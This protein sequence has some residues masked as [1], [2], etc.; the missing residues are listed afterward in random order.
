VKYAI[1][2][3][4]VFCAVSSA[5]AVWLGGDLTF[6]SKYIWRGAVFN[7]KPVLQ[8]WVASGIGGASVTVWGN[9]DLTDQNSY[10]EDG[11]QQDPT[12]KFTEI[13]L[14]LNYSE[15]IGPVSLTAGYNKYWYP[16]TSYS[17]TAASELTLSA[18]L[19]AFL[20]PTLTSA[21]SMEDAEGI[22]TALTVS[23][24]KTLSDI[25]SAGLSLNL[26]YGNEKH[27]GYY[28][29]VPEGGLADLTVNLSVPFA[30]PCGLSVT[31]M[32]E[33]TSLLDSE[34]SD[35]FEKPSNVRGGL[36]LTYYF[37]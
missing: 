24:S 34:V 14:I 29:G 30:L 37:L 31:P 1:L 28:Y 5:S 7:D 15:S 2:I 36:S 22:Y 25:V 23:H 17:E 4:A 35:V 26:G 21:F 32:I 33:Y 6:Q 10:I 27:N 11:D 20:Y 18:G 9:M 19:D 12:G 13:D 8:P 16:N 3:T